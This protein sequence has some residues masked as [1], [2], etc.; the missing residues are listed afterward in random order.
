MGFARAFGGNEVE[1][2][3]KAF[4]EGAKCFV[5]GYHGEERAV[6]FP[7]HVS[8]E[9]IGDAV[10]F[11]GSEE[12]DSFGSERRKANDGVG[13]ERGLQFREEAGF[14]EAAFDFGAHK[15][16]VRGGVYEF[17]VADDVETLVEKNAGDGVD[18]TAAVRTF[19]IQ[20]ACL[21]WRRV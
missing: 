2:N 9:D 18:E 4:D 15:E 8:D 19:D 10:V 6:E 11:F 17:L 13:A 1:W 12:N 5:V 20:D 21:H 14:V 7:E 3:S 16:A